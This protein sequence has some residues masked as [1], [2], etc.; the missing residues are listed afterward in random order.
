MIL[1]DVGFYMK[2]KKKHASLCLVCFGKDA[3]E[4]NL[5]TKKIRETPLDLIDS[6]TIVLVDGFHS[7]GQF[8]MMFPMREICA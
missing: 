7:D 2:W 6:K 5:I 1:D 4:H 3:L 8:L